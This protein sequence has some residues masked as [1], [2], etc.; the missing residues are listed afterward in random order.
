[1][2]SLVPHTWL[3][4]LLLKVALFLYPRAPARFLSVERLRCWAVARQPWAAEAA[5]SRS[6]A[7]VAR[8]VV[9]SRLREVLRHTVPAGL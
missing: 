5:L 2:A 8:V 7:V 3:V 9:M 1:M 6:S 4:A